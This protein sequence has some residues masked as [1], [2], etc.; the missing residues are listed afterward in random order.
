MVA[1]FKKKSSTSQDSYQAS[2]L[3]RHIPPS[4]KQRWSRWISKRLPPQAKVTLS[5]KG[6][7][8][9]PSAFG[10]AWLALI[11]LLYL[12]GTNYQNNLVI[13]LSLLLGSV[14]HTCIIYSYKN[15]AGL[16]FSAVTPADA[17]AQQSHSFPILLTGHNKQTN[18]ASVRN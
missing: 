10:F 4:I 14:F 15:L 5:H 6:I 12:F 7:F 18:T 9:L 8:I 1:L 16:T 13:G 17:Y 2:W 3:I 11:L